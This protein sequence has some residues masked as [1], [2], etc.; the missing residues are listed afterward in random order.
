TPPR[1][2]VLDASFRPSPAQGGLFTPVGSQSLL[3]S[4]LSSRT[5]STSTSDSRKSSRV[6]WSDPLVSSEQMAEDYDR[7]P[8]A[9]KPRDPR[10]R[11]ADLLSEEFNRSRLATESE[12]LNAAIVGASHESHQSEVSHRGSDYMSKSYDQRNTISE[13]AEVPYWQT[14]ACREELAGNPF[15]SDNHSEAE[16]EAKASHPEDASMY[17]SDSND[18]N[19]SDNSDTTYTYTAN[20][21]EFPSEGLLYMDEAEVARRTKRLREFASVSSSTTHHASP[22]AAPAGRHPNKVMPNFS[23]P[24]TS[25]VYHTGSPFSVASVTSSAVPARGVAQ[26]EYLESDAGTLPNEAAHL[27]PDS[28]AGLFGKPKNETNNNGKKRYS[29]LSGIPIPEHQT[30]YDINEAFPASATRPLSG[31]PVPPSCMPMPMPLSGIPIP[32][33][34]DPYFTSEG[35]PSPFSPLFDIP[36]STPPLSGM[37]LSGIPI[38]PPKTGNTG[39][40]SGSD[41]DS[42]RCRGVETV[43]RWLAR[44]GDG[45]GR[46]ATNVA[47]SRHSPHVTA[48]A[49]AD[50]KEADWNLNAAAAGRYF[51]ATDDPMGSCVAHTGHSEVGHA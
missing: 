37:P 51:W 33:P 28:T 36:T 35:T 26:P 25:C 18:N 47:D 41:S 34:S 6:E 23:Y 3:R 17:Y 19:M 40:G 10:V 15:L 39:N 2:P 45:E 20:N 27:A 22:S 12:R 11:I 7:S 8:I 21:P 13:G 46:V 31:I 42:F 49:F 9:T 1:S 32:S 5:P 50:G 14:E 4:C 43:F 30:V 48:R 44:S 24:K 38:P 16:A 29:P